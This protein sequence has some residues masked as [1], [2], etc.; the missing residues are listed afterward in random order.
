MRV[1][2]KLAA[3]LSS[4]RKVISC[5]SQIAQFWWCV[6]GSLEDAPR[7]QSHCV[8]LNFALNA[9]HPQLL[10]LYFLTSNRKQT[11]IKTKMD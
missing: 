4:S 8:A 11:A 10:L 1:C 7:K 9:S 3:T 2:V 6:E 5:V